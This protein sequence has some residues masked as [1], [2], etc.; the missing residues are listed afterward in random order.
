MGRV[1]KGSQLT[2]APHK[3]LLDVEIVVDA[4]GVSKAWGQMCWGY[5]DRRI[6]KM[7]GKRTAIYL[8]KKTC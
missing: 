7:E 2:L 8:T 6:D 5:H 4:R 1:N 3:A